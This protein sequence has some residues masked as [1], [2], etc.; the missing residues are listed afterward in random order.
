MGCDW[1]GRGSRTRGGGG[2]GR[3]P[4]RAAPVPGGCV[5]GE[6]PCSPGVGAGALRSTCVLRRFMAQPAGPIR[7]A[8]QACKERGRRRVSRAVPQRCQDGAGAGARSASSARHRCPGRRPTASGPYVH[9]DPLG[10]CCL[11]AQ[12]AGLLSPQSTQVCSSLGVPGRGPWWPPEL[13]GAPGG[14]PARIHGPQPYDGREDHLPAPGTSSGEGVLAPS[15]QVS[16]WPAAVPPAGTGAE[17]LAGRVQ[18]P[19]HRHREA[20]RGC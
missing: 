9:T 12:Q 13:R 5:G 3:E 15:A 17:G 19:T 10:A 1:S 4:L 7:W 18:T 16:T 14:Q 2:G 11:W 20:P 8:F 6:G